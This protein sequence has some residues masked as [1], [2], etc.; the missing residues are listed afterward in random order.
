MLWYLPLEHLEKRYTKLMDRQLV[1]AFQAKN[2]EYT[3]VYPE[4][5]PGEIEVG[6]FLDAAG[7]SYFKAGQLKAIARAFKEGLVKD[8]DKF[9]FSD[10]WFPG[11]ESLPYM[12]FF[13]KIDIEIYGVLHAGSW[14]PTDFVAQMGPWTTYFEAGLMN[15]VTKA[16]I[17]SYF[18]RQQIMERL[19]GI[20]EKL[21][22]TGLPFSKED[23]LAMAELTEPRPWS[24]R[25]DLVIFAGRLDD[26][27]QPWRFDRL[28]QLLKTDPKYANV[29]FVKTYEL[30]L[31]KFEYLDL[32]SRAKVIFSAALQENYGYAAL[33][34][35]ALG[36]QPVL[37][38]WVV[39]PEFYSRKNIYVTD[40]Q[41]VE[42]TKKFLKN[43][44]KSPVRP[45]AVTL[46][47]DGIENMISEMQLRK[48]NG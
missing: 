22:V 20:S 13:Y 27:K 5:L 24:E 29:K 38:N 48:G 14:T 9:F 11:I 3:R 33:E 37:P 36:V 34:A 44:T 47:E 17:G 7:T 35:V 46:I 15:I 43:T 6:A 19:S 45:K 25:E 8:G 21:I 18:H 2:V 16:F 31:D 28:E 12:A 41:A 1:D 39:Y 26:E 42:L 4:V 40:E 23:V 30:E 32:L 10:L